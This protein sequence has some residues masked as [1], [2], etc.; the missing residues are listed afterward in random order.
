VKVGWIDLEVRGDATAGHHRFG[1]GDAVSLWWDRTSD[2]V[3]A[4]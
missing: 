3:V 1:A 4:D 2:W